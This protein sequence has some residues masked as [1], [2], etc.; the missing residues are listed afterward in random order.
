[1]PALARVGAM[2]A[3]SAMAVMM[4]FF[5]AVLHFVFN[6][7]GGAWL[8]SPLTED[9]YSFN[10]RIFFRERHYSGRCR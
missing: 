5:I 8:L 2:A 3:P 7:V 10:R 4:I 1:T 6:G 9:G